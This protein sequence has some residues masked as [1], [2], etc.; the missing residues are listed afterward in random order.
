MEVLLSFCFVLLSTILA[1]WLLNFSSHKTK[2]QL[3][4]GPWILPIIGSLHHLVSVVPH[5]KITELCRRHGP[6]MFLKLG[7]LNT[8]VVSSAEAAALVMKTNDIKFASRPNNPTQRIISCDGR[9]IV[10]APYGEHW[11]QMRKVCI[12]ELLSSM[13]MAMS[14]SNNV[15]SRAVFG[16][17][18]VLQ[19]EYIRELERSYDR[20][21][22]IIEDVIEKRNGER[23]AG[24]STCSTDDEDLLDVLLRLQ[25]EDSLEL[26]LTRET[27]CA[28]LFDLFSAATDTTGTALEW[29]MSELVRHPEVMAKAQ[30][31]I[32]QVLGQ[33]QDVITHRGLAELQY[34]RMVIKEV[35][36]LH[37]S[38][39]IFP[40]MTREDCKILGYDMLKGTCVLVNIF[41]VSRDPKYWKNPE[42]FVP[43]RFENGTDYSGT[44]FEF[45][46]FGAG[47]RQ[48]PGMIF[49]TS[50]LEIALANLIYHFDWV[51]P[52]RA[53]PESLDMS[54]KFGM[55]VG[56]KYEL[57]LIAIPRVD[58]SSR[59]HI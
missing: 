31:E 51:L 50:T 1:L 24:D 13:Q 48:C 37:P 27:I 42:K 38:A 46:P 58:A 34:L 43:E 11:R 4:P 6:L 39:P 47:R 55:T 21:Q 3:P 28:V 20:M 30:A 22:H 40:R 9:G 56:R 53:S 23:A 5:R 7:E 45:T 35:L 36:R 26:P 8:V 44:N 12:V 49:A 18:F 2:H 32:Q 17:K 15:V 14:L 54:E 57:E 25:K 41:S 33:D 29:A 19:E 10:F 52:G 59:K 16:G